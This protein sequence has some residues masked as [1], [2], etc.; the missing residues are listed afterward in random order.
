MD[1]LHRCFEHPHLKMPQYRIS[2]LCV[3]FVDADL[4]RARKHWFAAKRYNKRYMMLPKKQVDE[5]RMRRRQANLMR[6]IKCAGFP[7]GTHS[8]TTISRGSF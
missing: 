2:D 6:Q 3:Y 8:V 5:V 1:K 4:R 7:K